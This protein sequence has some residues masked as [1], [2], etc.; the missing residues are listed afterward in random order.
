MKIIREKEVLCSEARDRLKVRSHSTER[1]N[2]ASNILINAIVLI[3]F[4][5]MPAPLENTNVESAKYRI[6]IPHRSIIA[7][8]F[9]IVDVSFN[10]DRAQNNGAHGENIKSNTAFRL[11]SHSC[12]GMLD[13]TIKERRRGFAIITKDSRLRRCGSMK[14]HK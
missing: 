14:A 12:N 9:R 4:A 2:V 11:P 6:I 7:V 13:V 10:A 3:I 1:G 8:P 5:Y